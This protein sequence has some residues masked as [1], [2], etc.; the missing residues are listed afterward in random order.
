[1]RID[2]IIKDVDASIAQKILALLPKD[3]TV[4][5]KEVKV[6]PVVAKTPLKEAPKAAKPEKKKYACDGCG[7]VFTYKKSFMKRTCCKV[8]EI[9]ESV[10]KELKKAPKPKRKFERNIKV[11]TKPAKKE[12]PKYKN[13]SDGDLTDMVISILTGNLNAIVTSAQI[14]GNYISIQRKKFGMTPEIKEMSKSLEARVVALLSK[15]AKALGPS[16]CM[17]MPISPNGLQ[18]ALFAKSISTKDLKKKLN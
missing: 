13:I 16:Q 1:M 4:T 7:K 8:I 5:V 12:K 9:K 6:A 2:L 3:E 10:S 17:S 11:P 18:V 15:A 14:S